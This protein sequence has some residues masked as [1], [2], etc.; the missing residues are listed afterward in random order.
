MPGS[1]IRAAL[2]TV[3]RWFRSILAVLVWEAIPIREPRCG[4]WD[5]SEVDKSGNFLLL[6]G[7]G[8]GGVKHAW[9]EL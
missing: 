5:E 2:I 4:G 8:N 9:L 1:G 3:C 6:E 7:P